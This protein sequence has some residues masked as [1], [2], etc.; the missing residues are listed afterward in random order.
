[1][2]YASG[3]A[4]FDAD[5]HIM[6]LPNFLETFADPLIRNDLPPISYSASAVSEAEAF[7]LMAQG[8]HSASHKAALLALGDDMIKGPKEIQALGAFDS[9]DRSTALDVLGFDKQLVFSTLSAAIPLATRVK[10]DP[11]IQYGAVRAHNRGMHSFCCDDE[12][13]LNVAILPLDD[14]DAAIGELDTVIE[15]GAGAVWIPHKPAGGRSPGHP[16]LDPIWSRLQE[17]RTPFVLHIGG[18]SYQLDPGWLNN[19]QSDAAD[20]LG[21][22]ENVRARDMLAMHHS[23]ELFIGMMVLDGVFERFRGLRGASVELGAGWVPALVSRL[24][25]TVDIWKKTDAA[26]A[27]LERKPSEQLAEQF[28]FTPYVYEP[29]GDLIEQTNPDLYLFSSDYP[30]MEGGRDPLGRFSRALA[31]Q[32]EPAREKFYSGNFKRLFL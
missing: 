1:M 31:S 27:K 13:L 24:D 14:L 9:A 5:S 18:I 17:T 11:R 25:W 8:G 20:W 7:E 15:E 23:P 32:T 3:R 28:G 10:T 19:G 16:D 30:H 26:L 4:F 29:V 22:G 21:G 12:R 6:E 2:T